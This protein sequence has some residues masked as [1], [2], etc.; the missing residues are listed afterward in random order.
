MICALKRDPSGGSLQE[1]WFVLIIEHAHGRKDDAGGWIV[2]SAPLAEA[3]VL[4]D[5]VPKVAET[6]LGHGE[7]GGDS[8][9]LELLEEVHGAPGT[10]G[11]PVQGR[12]LDARRETI[13]G[14]DDG[15]VGLGATALAIPHEVDDDGDAIARALACSRPLNEAIRVRFPRNEAK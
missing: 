13:G 12:S 5:G 4:A 14:G 15:V 3:E 7:G 10:V 9:L 11:S 8:T 1:F 2:D 6:V